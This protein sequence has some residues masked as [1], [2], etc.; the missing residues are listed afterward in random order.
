M[1]IFFFSLPAQSLFSIYRPGCSVLGRPQGHWDPDQDLCC[2]LS[3]HTCMPHASCVVCSR[4][5]YKYKSHAGSSFPHSRIR[6]SCSSRRAKLKDGGELGN[7]T[8]TSRESETRDQIIMHTSPPHRISAPTDCTGRLP[9]GSTIV[10]FLLHCFQKE[11]V[12]VERIESSRCVLYFADGR[13]TPVG[14]NE[15]QKV[16]YDCRETRLR[17]ADS[18]LAPSQ[19]S[20]RNASSSSL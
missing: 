8:Q 9:R 4:T 5:E 15:R 19:S 10:N 20:C 16:W 18:Y 13:L 11:S 6:S 1:S 2:L 3:R 14:K 12:S 17:R 7:D